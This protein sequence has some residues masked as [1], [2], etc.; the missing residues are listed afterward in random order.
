METLREL[1]AG[2][3]Y[4]V[5]RWRGKETDKQARRMAAHQGVFGHSRTRIMNDS[6]AQSE[7]LI[8]G[9]REKKRG[10]KGP[11]PLDDVGSGRLD[12]VL[13]DV[14]REVYLNSERQWLA[15]GHV[16][17]YPLGAI[18]REKS[19][20]FEDQVV[21]ELHR[22][23]YTL[24]GT[25]IPDLSTVDTRVTLHYRGKQAQQGQVY[26]SRRYR[27]AGPRSTWQSLSFLVASYLLPSISVWRR[28]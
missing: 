24:R 18:T 10:K 28:G 6:S 17:D 9:G 7:S 14:E 23:G 19:E 21:R 20:S 11:G 25:V 1:W 26:L 12:E 13:V 4:M 22:K 3:I 16:H 2:V 8:R 27:R 15:A 5:Q